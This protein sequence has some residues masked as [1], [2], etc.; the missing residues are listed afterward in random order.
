MIKKQYNI[1][2]VEIKI[3]VGQID[4]II[5][6]RSLKYVYIVSK[7]DMKKA[8]VDKYEVKVYPFT[9]VDENKFDL[10][11]ELSEEQKVGVIILEIEDSL[12]DGVAFAVGELLTGISIVDKKI[13]GITDIGL[14]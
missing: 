14:R 4:N 5:E 9:T 2:S 10:K 8:T 1:D 3:K 13:V 6:S 12:I 11:F 7:V